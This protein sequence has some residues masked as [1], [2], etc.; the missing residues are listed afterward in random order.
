MCGSAE[1]LSP[2][3][4][5]ALA[6]ACLEAR[7]TRSRPV[8]SGYSVGAALLGGDGTLYRAGNIECWGQTPSICAERVAL[9]KALSEG[10]ADFA[11][12]A[13]CGG[14]ADREPETFC[15]PCGVCRQVLLQFCPP[16]M[17]VLSVKGPEEIRAYTLAQL[18]PDFWTRPETT[19]QGELP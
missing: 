17:P 4:R 11:A 12:L 13:V 16:E 9:F 10:C 18:L 1:G 6:E 8:I 2:A 5:Q 3:V 19:S 15:T 14:T 7:R